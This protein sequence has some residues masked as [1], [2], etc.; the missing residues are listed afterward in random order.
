[1]VMAVLGVAFVMTGVILYRP[2]TPAPVDNVL[3]PGD[4]VTLS[5]GIEA[6]ETACS[7]PHDAIVEV[8]VPL[9]QICPTD[10]E[11]YRDRQGMGTACVVRTR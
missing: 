1:M 4:C 8:L 3:R 6:A 7:G 2:P 10:T 5:V 9:D 11:A